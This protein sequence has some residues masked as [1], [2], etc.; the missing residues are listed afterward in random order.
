MGLDPISMTMMVGS[1][2]S[3][4]SQIQGGI[5]ADAASKVN[6]RVLDAEARYTGTQ[7]AAGAAD[8]ARKFDKFRGG[9]RGDLAAA[10]GSVSSGSGLLLAQEAARQAKLDELNIIT[11]GVNR[12]QG[13]RTSARM[14]RFEG[15]A[16]RRQGVL[17]GLGSAV[18]GFAT[19]KAAQ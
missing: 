6:A 13:L 5:A 4:V 8:V 3:A 18:Q 17:G 14:A 9:L 15:A 1:G 2:L 10:G 12:G 7:A 16:A 11:E 19:W